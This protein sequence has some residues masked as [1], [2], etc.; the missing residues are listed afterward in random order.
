MLSKSQQ[1][2]NSSKKKNS[3]HND[4][5]RSKGTLQRRLEDSKSNKIKKNLFLTL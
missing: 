1:Q 3:Q 4:A 2:Q 5:T